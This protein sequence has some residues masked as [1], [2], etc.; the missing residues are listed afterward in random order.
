MLTYDQ[1]Q[2]IKRSFKHGDFFVFNIE[3]RVFIA[4]TILKHRKEAT[5]EFKECFEIDE[6]CFEGD[7]YYGETKSE[8]KV[9]ILED[10]YAD[11]ENVVAS[12]YYKDEVKEERSR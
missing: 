2:K 9:I 7:E 4:G 5:I 1:V 10:T 12:F 8:E 3:D 11:Y 6:T